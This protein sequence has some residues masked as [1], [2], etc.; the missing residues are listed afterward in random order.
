M[1]K[2]I[3][4]ITY[5]VGY[6]GVENALINMLKNTDYS[7]YNIDLLLTREDNEFI[8]E[9]PKEVNIII[10]K[11][12][13]LK[14]QFKNCLRD[15]KIIEAL[16]IL[17]IY[18]LKQVKK[19][20]ELLIKSMN[21]KDNEQYDYAI[22]YHS[23][24]QMQY[25]HTVNAKY[26][27]GFVHCNPYSYRKDIE[28]YL[29][30]YEK[31]DL[32]C[33]VS[34]EVK[35]RMIEIDSKLKDKVAVMTN[36]IDIDKIK[37]LSRSGQGFQDD[38]KG[39]RILTVGRLTIEKGYKLV[40]EVAKK[41]FENNY[42]FKWYIVGD[43]NFRNEFENK[44]KEYNL[45]KNCVVLGYTQN[46]YPYMRECDIYV[47]PSLSESYCITTAEGKAFNLPVVITN[48]PG[49]KEQFENM[50]TGIITEINAEALYKGIVKIL[51]NESLKESIVINLSN[52]AK[53]Y[54]KP[55]Q[56]SEIE[57]LLKH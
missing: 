43:G 56:I 20:N 55:D 39:I 7:K 19:E 35:D 48:T 40:L 27:I 37:K 11:C 31:S 38:Y 33:C 15:F 30:F 3:L 9:I 34:S 17:K 8:H 49:S 42:K 52:E 57:E 46:P 13:S 14:E 5:S 25:I 41:L 26:K 16:K 6:G 2:K 4:I 12:I 44:I 23:F 47:Q 36:I 50:K 22:A 1:K 21:I 51:E 18:I 32:I 28:K 29:E 10:K 53:N 24:F 54:I 45:Q